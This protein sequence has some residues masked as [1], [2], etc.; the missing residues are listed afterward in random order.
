[1]RKYVSYGKDISVNT[2]IFLRNCR[3]YRLISRAKQHMMTIKII[4]SK[5]ASR[6]P[7]W[8]VAH[9]E[10]FWLFMKGKFDPYVL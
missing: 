8:L 5:V 9:P 4:Y 6:S 10:I 3:Q 7:S 2:V 1:M